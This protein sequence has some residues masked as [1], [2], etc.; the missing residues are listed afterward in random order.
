MNSKAHEMTGTLVVSLKKFVMLKSSSKIWDLFVIFISFSS[1]NS[2][3]K[4]LCSIKLEIV[5]LKL[6]NISLFH[7]LLS[8]EYFAESI[9]SDIGFYGFRC[10]S[11]F[12][13]VFGW[14]NLKQKVRSKLGLDRVKMGEHCE[15]KWVWEVESSPH[16]HGILRFDELNGCFKGFCYW[17]LLSPTELKVSFL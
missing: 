12:Q 6:K 8:K 15:R 2:A 10:E 7:V 3:E 17:F 4:L 16:R 14:C 11:Y 1:W 13:Y 9:N 5:I